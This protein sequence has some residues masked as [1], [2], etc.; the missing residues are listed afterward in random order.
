MRLIL[1]LLYQP[2]TLKRASL[3]NLSPYFEENL[4]MQSS[5]LVDYEHN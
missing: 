3:I 1:L 2:V 4:N 5:T